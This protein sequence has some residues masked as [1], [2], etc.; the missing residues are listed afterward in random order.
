[1]NT[2]AA[3][4]AAK[5]EASRGVGLRILP[6]AQTQ[7]SHRTGGVQARHAERQPATATTVEAVA[8]EGIAALRQL[9]AA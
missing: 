5:R 6:G 2:C 1:M 3:Q 7:C 8:R 9:R 4:D